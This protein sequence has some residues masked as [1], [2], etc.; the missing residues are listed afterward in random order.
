DG[1]AELRELAV[2][3][4]VALRDEDLDVAPRAV[5]RLRHHLLQA[6]ALAR[7]RSALALAAVLAAALVVLG[8]LG[9]FRHDAAGPFE[10]VLGGRSGGSIPHGSAPSG[11]CLRRCPRIRPAHPR[12][13][14][15]VPL[16]VRRRWGGPARARLAARRE[17][18]APRGT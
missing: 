17:A 2:D 14:A 6:L 1:I 11:R 4:D 10:L 8:R 16:P 18:A 5:A 12:I 7:A 9:P 13:A 15:G 3:R